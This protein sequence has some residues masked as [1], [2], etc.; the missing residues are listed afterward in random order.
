MLMLLML[1]KPPLTVCCQLLLLLLL[2]L[3]VPPAG[4]LLSQG[5]PMLVLYELGTLQE[6]SCWTKDTADLLTIVGA[7]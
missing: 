6:H 2:L 7:A 4:V 1:F 5:K 3:L